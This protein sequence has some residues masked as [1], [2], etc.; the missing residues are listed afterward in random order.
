MAQSIDNMRTTGIV[1]SF[2]ILWYKTSSNNS[3]DY[4]PQQIYNNQLLVKEYNLIKYL[5]LTNISINTLIN[6]AWFVTFLKLA[7]LKY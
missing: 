4:Y 5:Q 3:N 7:M 6:W 1:K 2:Q